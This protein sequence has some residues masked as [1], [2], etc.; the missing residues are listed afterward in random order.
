MGHSFLKKDRVLINSLKRILSSLGV[1]CDSGEKP[2]GGSVSMKVLERLQRN[3]IFVGV[4]TKRSRL[5]D[6]KNWTTSSW[7]VEEKA[8]AIDKGK[9][10]LLLVEEGVE[11]IGGLQGDYEYVRFNRSQFYES[12]P[13][14]VD[15]IRSITVSDHPITISISNS[16]FPDMQSIQEHLKKES[17]NPQAFVEITRRLQQTGRF[18][19]AERILLEG[20]GLYPENPEIKYHLANVVRRNNKPEYSKQIFEE[21]IT[22]DPSADRLHHNFA[23]LLEEDMGDIDGALNHF[24]KAL[25]IRPNSENFRCYGICLY[26]KAMSIENDI[27]RKQTFKKAKRLLENAKRVQDSDAKDDKGIEAF[28]LNIESCLDEE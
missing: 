19:D 7:V 20:L 26:R 24:Q 1:V 14:I 12:I 4:F 2:E 21:L 11:E 5:A 18:A 13:K 16:E 8:A 10:L 23:H 28:I 9:R 3:D 22:K 17:A 27:V 6:S 15:Y 25:D